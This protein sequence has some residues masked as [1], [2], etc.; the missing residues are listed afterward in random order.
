MVNRVLWRGQNRTPFNIHELT[1]LSAGGAVEG[2]EVD[3]GVV[4]GAQVVDVV[5]TTPPPS[6]ARHA[7]VSSPPSKVKVKTAESG[8]SL[9]QHTGQ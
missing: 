2:L 5:P 6:E 4:G 7:I 1:P 3:E 9:R 8:I